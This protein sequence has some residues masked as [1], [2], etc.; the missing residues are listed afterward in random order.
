ENHL[1]LHGRHRRH[2][3]Q[4]RALLRQRDP[5]TFARDDDGT[6]LCEI[7]RYGEHRRRARCRSQILMFDPKRIQQAQ[8]AVYGLLVALAL[9]WLAAIVLP[10]YWAADG[11]LLSALIVRRCFS[12]VCHQMPERSFYLFGHP[13]AV[14][15]RCTGIYFGIAVGMICYPFCRA[16]YRI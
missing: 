14:C 16:L 9:L 13:L 8:R 7:H 12:L 11:E 1:R 3:T 15:A 10:A 5:H 4:R 6:A 2:D